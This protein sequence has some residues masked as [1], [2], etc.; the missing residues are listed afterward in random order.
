MSNRLER[1]ECLK[2]GVPL[3]RT[4]GIPCCSTCWEQAHRDFRNGKYKA[5]SYYHFKKKPDGVKIA[6]SKAQKPGLK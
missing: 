3:I 1:N 6:P 5:R 4:D 2:C